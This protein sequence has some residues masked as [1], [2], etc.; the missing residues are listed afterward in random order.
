MVSVFDTHTQTPTYTHHGNGIENNIAGCELFPAGIKLAARF[1]TSKP[2]AFQSLRWFL[3]GGG[4]ANN[5]NG[6]ENNSPGL[7]R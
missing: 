1:T 5:R 7:L 2:N 4:V 3:G 6:I